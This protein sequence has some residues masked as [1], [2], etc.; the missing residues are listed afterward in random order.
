MKTVEVFITTVDK[1]G[2]IEELHLGRYF[3]H[4]DMFTFLS[5]TC[6]RNIQYLNAA[7][8]LITCKR[9]IITPNALC[10]LK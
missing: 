9:L 5:L 10:K 4:P 2:I 1:G 8:N 3:L 6:I 7:H